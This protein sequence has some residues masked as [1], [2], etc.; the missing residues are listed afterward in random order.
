MESL[1][2]ILDHRGLTLLC[3]A[4]VMDALVRP[5]TAEDLAGDLGLDPERLELFLR[6]G[7]ARGWLGM[8]RRGRFQPNR[9]TEFLR[10]DHPGGWRAQADLMSGVELIDSIQGLSLEAGSGHVF[11]EVHGMTYQDWLTEHPDRWEVFDR[12]QAIGGRVHGF[13]LAKGWNW[14]GVETVCD[15]GGGTGALLRTLLDLRPHLRGVLLDLPPVVARAAA[16]DRLEILGGDAFDGVPPGH[17]IYLLVNIVHMWSDVDAARILRQVA[18]AA[19]PTT[20]VLLVESR[21]EDIPR[22]DMTP[23]LDVVMAALTDGGVERGRD[24]LDRLARTAGLRVA[25]ATPLG[26]GDIAYELRAG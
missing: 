11:E 9:V 15:V 3:Q 23:Y 4:G 10:T 7:V 6:L 17:D 12:A 8:D 25:S 16:H 18:S 1:F 19:K 26:T 24:D 20:S 5:V 2:G 14:E 13:T 21:R 22:A